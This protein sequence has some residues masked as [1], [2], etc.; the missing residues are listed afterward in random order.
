MSTLKKYRVIIAGG[1]TGGHIFPAVAIAQGLEKK[2]G[3]D[4]DLLF[5]G[6][7]GRMEM[8]KVPAL[9]YKIIGLEV[10]G[11]QRSFSLKNFILPFKIIKSLFQAI[12]VIR[13]FKP[14]LAI[15]VGGYA[16][17]PML[18]VAALFGVP[19]VIQE[20]N[21]YPGI[22]NKILSK[23]AKKIFVAYDGLDIFFD[24]EKI[25]W[26]GNPIRKDISGTLPNREIANQFFNLNPNKKT[27]LV[28]GGSLGARTLNQSVE[29]KIS[30][31]KSNNYQLIWQ[32][33]KLYYDAILHRNKMEEGD[34][35]IITDFLKQ[36]DMAYACA[37][38]II[39][40]AGALSISEL[41]LVGKPVVFVPSPNVSED[42]Q[43]KNAMALVKKEA[44][45]L[46]ADKDANKILIDKTFDLLNDDLQ[47]KHLGTQILKLAKPNA[48]EE[49][50]NGILTLIK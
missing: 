42:H 17:G 14:N 30:E 20:Q 43:T 3:N 9:G 31:I 28:I 32:T 40:R 7:K 35:I 22:T 16:S 25:E 39:S 21:S 13:K 19:I 48:S 44:A 29:A 6:A 34:G 8:E 11:F 46:V 37:D 10:A 26:C 2:L 38:I 15:G 5:V 18:F 41:C 12:G 27:I 45:V 24:K 23:W 33:G 50:V 4:L 36:M 47:M 1:G 49:I